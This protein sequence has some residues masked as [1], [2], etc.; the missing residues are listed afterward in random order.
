MSETTN[1]IEIHKAQLEDMEEILRLQYIAYQSEA[2]IHGDFTIQPLTQTLEE[3]VEEFHKGVVLK[4]VLNGVIIGSVRAYTDNG[5]TYIGKL[6]VCPEY[7][8]QGLGKELLAAIEGEFS[9]KRFELYTSCKSDR[10]LHIYETAG[11][12]RMREETDEAG[13]W[14]AY[15]EKPGGK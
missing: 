4:A 12:K 14:F 7:R 8:G 10:N 11:Y 2:L 5:T 9:T 1:V 13:I 3:T 6:M 15:L